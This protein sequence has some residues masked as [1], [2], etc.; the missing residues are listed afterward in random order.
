MRRIELADGADLAQWRD[1][2]RALLADGVPP[3]QVLW[4][5][6]AQGDLLGSA[7]GG[8]G[9]L[10]AADPGVPPGAVGG[11]GPPTVAGRAVR[12][13]VRVPRDFLDLADQLGA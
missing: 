3:D 12:S 9:S 6:G 11:A 8:Q 5:G 7:P 10:L 13:D 4:T 2:A 1:A